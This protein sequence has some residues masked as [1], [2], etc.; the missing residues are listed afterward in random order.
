MMG[1]TKMPPPSLPQPV[2]RVLDWWHA[3]HFLAKTS[4]I[5]ETLEVA[6][7]IIWPP[8]SPAQMLVA[9][10]GWYWW[11]RCRSHRGCCAW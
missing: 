11:R 4:V 1:P 8:N 3:P 9:S 10:L 5:V 2:R 7:M 6:S